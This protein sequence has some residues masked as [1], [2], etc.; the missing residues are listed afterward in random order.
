MNN[1]EKYVGLLND[2]AP[3]GEF[4]AYINEEEAE[5]LKDNGALGLLTPQG[6]PSYIGGSYSAGG[7]GRYQGGSGAPGSAES[8]RSTTTNSG[9]SG[10]GGG[11]RSWAVTNTAAQKKQR[12]A[13]EKAAQQ[14]AAQQKAAEAKAKA[15]REAQQRI[16]DAE[17]QERK[18]QEAA[19]KAKRQD[20]ARLDYI[21]G[22]Y[23]DVELNPEQKKE[24]EQ[25]RTDVRESISP[26]T[27]T[28]NKIIGG[29]L[30]SILPGAGSLYNFYLDSTAMGY[31]MP[32][33]FEN[34][35]GGGGE[36]SVE[37]VNNFIDNAGSDS[38][39]I[40]QLVQSI[41]NA[42][43]PNLPD[44]QV[45]Q[46]FSNMNMPQGSPL[47]SDLQ[48]DYNSAKN[49]INNILGITPPSQQFGYSADPYGGLMASN[50]TTNPYNIDYLRRLGLI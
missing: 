22:K 16:R 26:S 42:I 47:S 23:L 9:N 25:Y 8:P 2:I 36:I 6:I 27:K 11:G 4:L 18:R 40:S 50:L 13:Q 49:N 38:N 21:T 45:D 12:L 29:L 28:S 31:K 34:L 48:T 39:V 7:G 20:D 33:P 1:L 15:E 32:N 10:G 30:S 37:D 3:K 35:F 5:M 41:S 19:E 44:S 14:K 46:Y 17:N 43:N 24:F